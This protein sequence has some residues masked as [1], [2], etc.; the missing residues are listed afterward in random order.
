MYLTLADT[1]VKKVVVHG[2]PGTSRFLSAGQAF[3]ENRPD[4]EL[5]SEELDLASPPPFTDGNVSIQPFVAW[6]DANPSAADEAVPQ[7]RATPGA[8][9]DGEGEREG[10]EESYASKE[11]KHKAAKTGCAVSYALRFPD[12]QGK[13]D[14]EKAKALGGTSPSLRSTVYH[15]SLDARPHLL[16]PARHRA[17]RASDQ[18][19]QASPPARFLP[20]SRPGRPSKSRAA[21]A[22][23]CN[24]VSASKLAPRGP[25]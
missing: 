19:V 12:V 6:P 15:A 11:V 18:G 25:A 5:S 4:A 17:L 14:V 8:N 13:F 1:G 10:G 21:R 9:G 22:E 23:L 3:C 16:P 20:V 2:P 24:P 7:D